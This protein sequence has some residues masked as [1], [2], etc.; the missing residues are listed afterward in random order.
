MHQSRSPDVVIRSSPDGALPTEFRVDVTPER[1]AVRVSPVGEIDLAT[2][3]E[4]RAQLQELTSAGF[5]N[6]ILDLRAT[7]FLDST[8]L[9]LVM[10]THSAAHRDGIA[11]AI[12]AGPAAVHRV[13][14]V[15]GLSG[16]LPFV[17]PGAWRNGNGW[18]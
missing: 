18:G 14:E 4:V 6:V 13:F 9:R 10:D 3:G 12:V 1:D 7:T 16:R 11:F 2:A 8:G 15:A 17:E 5:T